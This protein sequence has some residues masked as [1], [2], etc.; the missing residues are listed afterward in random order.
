MVLVPVPL[1]LAPL[2]SPKMNR[3]E[4]NAGRRGT[5]TV[6]FSRAVAR[7]WRPTQKRYADT[8]IQCSSLHK[9][10]IASAS[11]RSRRTVAHAASASNANGATPSDWTARVFVSRSRRES[12]LVSAQSASIAR[13]FEG[14]G[15]RAGRRAEQQ[16]KRRR[17]GLPEV[18]NRRPGRQSKD[19]AAPHERVLRA[20]HRDHAD[21]RSRRAL[22][23]HL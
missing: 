4:K 16:R 1:R 18:A 20:L 7:V 17:S 19:A 8:L 5:S 12:R 3:G 15:A 2:L 6:R 14:R 9:C 13:A 21:P 22:A 11:A 23:P 10:A